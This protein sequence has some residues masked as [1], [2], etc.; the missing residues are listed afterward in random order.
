M[1]VLAQFGLRVFSTSSTPLT[2]WQYSLVQFEVLIIAN[3]NTIWADFKHKRK[4]FYIRATKVDTIA[5]A[6]SHSLSNL[7]IFYLEK[8]ASIGIL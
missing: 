8:G 3:G 2:L 4:A 5:E 1:G 6:N 7:N